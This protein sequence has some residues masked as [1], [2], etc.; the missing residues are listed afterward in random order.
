MQTTIRPPAVA[1]MF[2]PA[3]AAALHAELASLLPATSAQPQVQPKALLVPHAGYIYSGST[4]GAAYACLTPWRQTIRRVVL[5]GPC[6]RVPVRGMALSSADAFAT[7][8]GN[9]P[10]VGTAALAG[11]PEVDIG[12]NAHIP[13]HSLEVQLPFLQT[14]LE[15]FSLIPIVV[16]DAVPEA[17]AV[18]LERLWGGDE[19]LIVVSSDL[20]HYLPYA[21]AQRIDK[22]TCDTILGLQ[23]ELVPEQACGAHPLNGLLLAARRHHLRPQLLACCNSGDTAGDR[24]RVVGYAAVAFYPPEAS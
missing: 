21:T 5:L 7:P 13:E 19:T 3:N 20:S 15:V 11:L 2:Y 8:L 10:V 1:G 6:H 18:V 9:V 23:A 16:G 24:E 22:L 17:V 4:A 12:D 14:V